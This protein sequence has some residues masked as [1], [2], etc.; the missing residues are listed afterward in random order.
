M[1]IEDKYLY[2]LISCG[3]HPDILSKH[4]DITPSPYDG[5]IVYITGS[6]QSELYEVV[7]LGLNAQVTTGNMPLINTTAFDICASPLVGRI[8]FVT[9][10]GAPKT[11]RT[12][13]LP[14]PYAIGTI[15][16]FTGEDTCWEVVRENA[17]YTESLTVDT[18]FTTCLDCAVA[19]ADIQCA[20]EE[21]T[22]A[23]AVK[24]KIPPAEPADRG[25]AECCYLN[26]VFG[27]LGS[28]E[29]YKNDFNSV[30][31]KRQ[32]ASDTVA[33]SLIGESTGTTALVDSTHGVLYPFGE[34]GQPDLSYFKVEWRKILALL[35]ED[36]YKIRMTLTIAG[37]AV[38]KD[39]FP[40]T[41][42]QFTTSLADKTVRIDS[43]LDGT[44]VKIDTDFRNS[45]YTNSLRFKGFFGNA[46]PNFEQDN[47]VFSSKKGL[48]YY[49]S[50]IN[51]SNIW[52][53]VFTAYRV[54]ECM[55][56]VFY[57]E[58]IWG[59]DLYLSDYNLNNHSYF[60]SLLPV[61]LKEDNNP[62]YNALSRLVD[63]SLT[64]TD[65]AKNNRKTNC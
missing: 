23:Y 54:P 55:A 59:N 62:T 10:C 28:T 37:V 22:L 5:L 21:R 64:F 24:I 15:L 8:F 43:N 17:N 58:L 20:Y 18:A 63:L 51:M 26:L 45:G 36:T 6:P 42:R 30:F 49:S 33:Y 35:G 60:Y 19:I 27:D 14:I 52:D 44:I 47:V 61:E 53:Y 41:L 57:N 29:S 13:L 39:T 65:R 7:S 38:T 11:A 1:A 2:D 46:T 3:A 50:Q 48:P 56:R 34:V 4:T 9:L 16:R 12:V 25:F 40:F 31:Y 32:T